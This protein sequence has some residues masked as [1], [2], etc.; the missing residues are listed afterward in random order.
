MIMFCQQRNKQIIF[1]LLGDGN[2]YIED[3]SALGTF[4]I[5][6]GRNLALGGSWQA[7]GHF[8]LTAHKPDVY[9]DGH[10]IIHNGQIIV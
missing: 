4:H 2:C 7:S 9:A 3:E 8:D 6:F 10:K 5:G 1:I